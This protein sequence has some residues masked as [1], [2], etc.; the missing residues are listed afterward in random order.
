MRAIRERA[1]NN[2]G[3]NTTTI[4]AFS[5]PLLFLLLLYTSFLSFLIVSFLL[6]FFHSLYSF[7]SWLS[8]N[9]VGAAV[10]LK[11]RLPTAA[12]AAA[13]YTHWFQM[14]TERELC[15]SLLI[16]YPPILLFMWKGPLGFVIEKFS[17]FSAHSHIP[18]VDI[19]LE[20]EREGEKVAQKNVCT[21]S[22][23]YGY[24]LCSYAQWSL[25]WISSQ[26]A[27]TA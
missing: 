7:P 24:P 25:D 14:M 3:R 20:V 22:N 17:L 4:K 8:F 6:F 13:H 26:G 15:A 10:L 2:R 16:D 23:F 11:G 1:P 9:V 19:L 18:H 21:R 27:T 5:L 12:A